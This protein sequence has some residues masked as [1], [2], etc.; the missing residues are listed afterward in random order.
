MVG[1]TLWATAGVGGIAV[2]FW[3]GMARVTG[4]PIPSRI[5]SS[6][7][8]KVLVPVLAIMTLLLGVTVWT[9]DRRITYEFEADA[10]RSLVTAG[11]VFK[12]FQKDHTRNLLVRFRNL[13]K[14]PGYRALFQT[15]DP[16]TLK[17]LLEDLLGEQDV[18]VI[19]ATSSTGDVLAGLK[20]DPGIGLSEFQSASAL[21]V[22]QA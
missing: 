3:R 20:R 16:G 15:A 4:I 19:L 2:A 18:D 9:V 7:S 14:E 10:E 5:G 21:A 8:A 1:G 12:N 17:A 6:F 13:P 11:A 22:K